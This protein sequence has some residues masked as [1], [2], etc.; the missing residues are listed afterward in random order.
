MIYA[1]RLAP[2]INTLTTSFFYGVHNNMQ[3]IGD[4]IV[5]NAIEE[6]LD[7][8]HTALVLWD[9]LRAFTK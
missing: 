8:S 1:A 5:Y 9:V 6:I 3:K 4:K 2:S 7:P